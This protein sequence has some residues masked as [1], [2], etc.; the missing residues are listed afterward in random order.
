MKKSVQMILWVILFFAPTV[1]ACAADIAALDRVS[2]LMP[3][4]E[5]VS[6]LGVPDEVTVMGRLKVELYHVTDAS[7]LLKSGYIYENEA[8]LAGHAFIFQGN[9][10]AETAERLTE[11]GFAIL[12]EK[13]T[14]YRL[15]GKDDDTGRPVVVT[16][17]VENDLTTVV[18]FEKGFYERS[19]GR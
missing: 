12:D 10:A 9:C 15:T 16:I 7:P 13:G 3:R 2:V 6:I 18:T 4:T 1:T 14:A 8:A 11:H 5:V 17:N 19:A